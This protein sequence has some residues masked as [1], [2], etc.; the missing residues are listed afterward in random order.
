M[1]DTDDVVLW[2]A[3]YRLITNYWFEVDF[4]GG[5]NAHDSDVPDGY[6]VPSGVWLELK[7]A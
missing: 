4:N 7:V 1:P 2:Y 3:L 5:D 6:L